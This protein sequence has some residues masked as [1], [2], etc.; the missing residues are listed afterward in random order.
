M[1]KC[2]FRICVCY[3]GNHICYT[4]FLLAFTRFY[5]WRDFQLYIQLHIQLLFNYY[6]TS[7]QLRCPFH[8][9]QS[10]DQRPM[11][12]H[13]HHVVH[14]FQWMQSKG[15]AE[16]CTSAST[17][18]VYPFVLIF[19]HCRIKVVYGYITSVCGWLTSVYV[20]ITIARKFAT[21]CGHL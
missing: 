10:H 17:V 1:R 12:N 14:S 11:R 20:E 13:W 19:M 5:E 8:K 9:R 15:E 2:I 16:Q 7:I 4:F 18:D 3:E 21:A 6:S